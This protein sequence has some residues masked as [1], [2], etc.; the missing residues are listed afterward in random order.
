MQ[1]V[2]THLVGGAQ[3]GVREQHPS[4]RRAALLAITAAICAVLPNESAALASA[5]PSSSALRLRALPL[6]AAPIDRR[7]A[8]RISRSSR[9]ARHQRAAYQVAAVLLCVCVHALRLGV[10]R[11]RAQLGDGALCRPRAQVATL[12]VL[13]CVLRLA[14]VLHGEYRNARRELNRST[15]ALRSG[16]PIHTTG[17]TK[18]R[19]LTKGRSPKAARVAPG[20]ARERQRR[21][22]EEPITDHI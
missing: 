2:P 3:V 17:N 22:R 14:L 16:S 7:L 12:R 6:R 10:C 9:A 15:G 13:R 21:Q 5:P 18:V 4:A 20:L 19:A 1:R 8:I 11:H